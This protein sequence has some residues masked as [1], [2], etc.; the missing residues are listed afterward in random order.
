VRR[1]RATPDLNGAAGSRG[2]GFVVSIHVGAG[3]ERRG[4]PG[5]DGGWLERSAM[6]PSW[7][8]RAASLPREQGSPGLTGGPH[9]QCRAVALADK[10]ARVA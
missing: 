9:P 7:R 4:A 2:G 3:E 6:A 1:H 5:H 8:A 10:Q